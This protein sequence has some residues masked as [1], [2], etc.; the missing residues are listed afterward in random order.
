MDEIYLMPVTT[1]KAKKTRKSAATKVRLNVVLPKGQ[2]LAWTSLRRAVLGGFPDIIVSRYASFATL[3]RAKAEG[4]VLVLLAH[5]VTVVAQQIALNGEFEQAMKAWLAETS[6]LLEQQC[7]RRDRVIL[8]AASALEQGPSDLLSVLS[9][10]LGTL[11]KGD[12]RTDE[13]ALLEASVLDRVA[14]YHALRDSAAVEEILRQLQKVMV[15][16]FG[17]AGLAAESVLQLRATLL[18]EVEAWQTETDLLRTRLSAVSAEKQAAEKAHKAKQKALEKALTAAQAEADKLQEIQAAQ[19]TESD[20][21][22]TSLSATLAEVE[23]SQ[24]REHTQKQELGELQQQL[25]EMYLLKATNMALEQRLRLAEDRAASREG[26]LGKAV[27]LAG[28]RT[29][30]MG[31]EMWQ[32]QTRLQEDLQA[33]RGVVQARD[34]QLQ[35]LQLSLS[36]TLAEAEAKQAG[37]QAE[38]NGLQA[39]LDE[40]NSLLEQLSGEL[41]HIYTSKS[42]K[43]T[44]PMRQAR[45]YLLGNK[46]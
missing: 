32:M 45:A 27:L 39:Q 30:Q 26:I 40:S 28:Q 34:E 36:R 4:V 33:A 11:P 8:V 22:R 31:H 37:L 3:D 20:L 41:N 14:A 43:I 16:P 17:D 2:G 46:A 29:E 38:L 23:I 42:W 7:K 25:R 15:V 18:A 35:D 6:E 19:S 5:P 44:E 24:A 1:N 10:K 13:P 12:I 9:E 21:L